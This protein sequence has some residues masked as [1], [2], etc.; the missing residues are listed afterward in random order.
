MEPSRQTFAHHIEALTY[1]PTGGIVAA[2]TTSLPERLGGVRNWD[3]R[4]CWLRTRPSRFWHS[5]ISDTTKKRATGA[6]GSSAPSPLRYETESPR[7]GL[8]EG[9]GAFLACSFW[10]V[11]NYILLG[12]YA[13]ARKLF[14]RLLSRCNDVGLLAEEFDPLTGRMLGNFPQ[15]YSHVGLIN[16]ALSLSRQTGPIEERAE[17]D[18]GSIDF[19]ADKAAAAE[20][21][22]SP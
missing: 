2:V 11:D 20:L 8:P 13:E 15:A 7:D 3:Y 12:R 16:C 18:E 10:L 4:Y 1:A 21:T 14:E 17:P 19:A 6:T 22:R 5:C 9:E